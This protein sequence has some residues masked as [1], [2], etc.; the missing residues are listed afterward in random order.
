VSDLK[1]RD[2]KDSTRKHSPLTRAADA[3]EVDTTHMTL[4]EQVLYIVSKVKK[5]K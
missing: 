2:Q 5:V 3:V 4:G 1:I